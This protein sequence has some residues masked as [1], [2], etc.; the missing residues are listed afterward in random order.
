V[1]S[2][3]STPI[4]TRV[5][6]SIVAAIPSPSSGSLHLGPFQLRAYGLMIAL[7]V[8]AAVALGGRRLE[9]AG[10]GKRD[11]LAAAAMWGVPAGVIGARLYHVATDWKSFK[12]DWG[13]VF[14]VWEGGLGIWG[15][16]GLGVI[17]GVWAMRRRGISAANTLGAV[18]PA[19]ALAQAIGRWGNWWNQELFGRPT[20]LPWA[21][22]I[23]PANRPAA[24]ADSPTFHPTFLYESLWSLALCGA[25][26]WIDRRY[27]PRPLRL[28]AMY[29]A[30]YTLARFFIERLRVD[31]ASLVLGLRVNEW[32]A[33]LIF[34]AAVAYLVATRGAQREPVGAF[35]DGDI[36]EGDDE[37][38]GATDVHDHID[39]VDDDAD[40][41][42][43]VAA[44]RRSDQAGVFDIESE[45][46]ADRA[47]DV[48]GAGAGS[49]VI[50]EVERDPDR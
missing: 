6:A 8:I 37:H 29:V 34:L 39:A 2:S 9:W 26:L 1:L 7:G 48:V 17:V 4:S 28:F 44:P 30:G 25:L 27:R 41:A 21:L 45:A 43:D 31:K 12:G 24:Y 11:D 36:D 19:L 3:I 5:A 22:K 20:T 13:R 33:A 10:T 15:G 40:A 38:V 47:G 23:D 49:S 32:V 16:I 18:A 46:D 42:V 14:K 35:A 50:D